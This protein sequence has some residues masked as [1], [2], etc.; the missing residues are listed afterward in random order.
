MESPRGPESPWKQ[1]TTTTT[2]P[3]SV[4]QQTQREDQRDPEDRR[5]YLWSF[6]ADGAGISK[7]SNRALNATLKHHHE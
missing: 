4:E 6:G 5:T 2:T 7:R 3:L 1:T